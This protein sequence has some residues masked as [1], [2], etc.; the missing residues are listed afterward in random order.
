MMQILIL[1]WRMMRAKEGGVETSKPVLL[2][3][4][5]AV[6]RGEEASPWTP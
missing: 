4:A 5:G 6:S 3:A 2:S 1:M